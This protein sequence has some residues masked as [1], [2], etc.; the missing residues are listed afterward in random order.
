MGRC[1]SGA[2]AVAERGLGSEPVWHGGDE[3]DM[4]SYSLSVT[5]R[6]RGRRLQ[7][8]ARSGRATHREEEGG[9]CVIGPAR[10][11]FGLDRSCPVEHKSE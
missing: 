10:R 1:A 9:E 3:P 6:E 5:R 4:Q 7:A 11:S 8:I 2:G